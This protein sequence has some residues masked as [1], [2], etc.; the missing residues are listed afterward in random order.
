MTLRHDD[1]EL[2]ITAPFVTTKLRESK[3]DQTDRSRHLI[4]CTIPNRTDLTHRNAAPRD[5]A[6]PTARDTAQPN[7]T[8]PTNRIESARHWNRTLRHDT[9]RPY[10]SGCH[11]TWRHET[12]RPYETRPNHTV[13]HRPAASKRNAPWRNLTSP[14]IR[15]KTSLVITQ[16]HDHTYRHGA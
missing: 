6:K 16:R 4:L 10:V 13:R 1:T 2:D 3:R 9:Q 12:A 5:D 7:N 11:G 8:T 15:R 14:T